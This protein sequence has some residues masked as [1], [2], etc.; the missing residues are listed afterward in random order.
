MRVAGEINARTHEMLEAAVA[1]GVTTGELNKLADSYIRSRGAKPA[2]KGYRG[3]PASVCVSVNEE[4]IHGIPGL[5]KLLTGDIVSI[6]IGVL[7]NG[8][9]SDAARTFP[10][11]GVSSEARRLIDVARESFFAG[12][13]FARAGA[14]LY[15]ISGAINDYVESNGFSVVREWVGHGV[16]RALHEPPEIPNYRMPNRGPRLYPGMTLAIEPMV[17]AGT[18]E[19]LTRKDSWTVVTRDGRLSAHYENTVLVTA[20][21]PELLTLLG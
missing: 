8:F 18:Y 20:G 11:G 7:Y 9:Y 10:V 15:Q 13:A 6:D 1:P 21:E 2:F 19:I 3:F 16:G 12:I 14:H 17:N 4:V 5:K